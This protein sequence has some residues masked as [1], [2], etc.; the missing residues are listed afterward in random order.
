M[1][2]GKVRGREVEKKRDREVKRWRDRD[3]Y[4]VM[5]WLRAGE[6]QAARVYV[7]NST[8]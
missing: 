7:L 2:R 8:Y 1:V 3:S 4:D 5:C 6:V